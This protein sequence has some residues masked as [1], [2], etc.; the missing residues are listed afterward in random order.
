MNLIE[1]MWKELAKWRLHGRL[2][3]STRKE[4]E[5]K[6]QSVMILM[7]TVG[8]AAPLRGGGLN[9]RDAR[10]VLKPQEGH[11]HLAAQKKKTTNLLP[12]V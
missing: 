5:S 6:K 1:R 11:I 8:H 3:G 2:K 4:S 10:R 12:E 9:Q 7:T